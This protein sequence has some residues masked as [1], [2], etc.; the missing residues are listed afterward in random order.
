MA[1]PAVERGT[2]I[3]PPVDAPPA[4][5][6]GGVAAPPRPAPAPPRPAPAPA[7]PPA[8]PPAPPQQA[9]GWGL[10][11]VVLVTG[12][13]MSVLD[14]S[15]V[16]VAIPTMQNDFGVTTDEIQWVA[17]AYSLAL[18][19]VVPVSAYCADRFGPTRVYNISL[20]GFAA[21]SALCGLAWNLNSMIV[22]RVFQAI[23]G[24]V[25]PV[26]T[27]TILYRIVPKDRIG[28]A[29]GMY[30]LGIIV[31]PA[32]GPT[33]GGYLVEYVDWRLIFFINVPVGILGTIA[34]IVVLKK[35]P[36]VDNG[37]FDVVG[38]LC[39]ATG[40]F[41]LL[42]ALTE[43]Q[44]WGWTS[45]KV[46][47]L[48]TTGV[49]SLALFVIVELDVERPLLDVRV[50]RYWPFT[51]S[52]LLISVL[53]VGLFSVLFYVP[54]FLQQA[55]GLGA[56]E[57]GLL[58]LPQALV[59]AVCM[60]I[61]GRLYDRFGPRW[62]AVIGLSINAWG[63]YEMHVLTLDTT[64]A[65]LVWLLCLRAVGMGIGM[66][67]IMTGG[68]ASVPPSQV[69]RASAFN[70]VVQRTSAALGLAILTAVVTRT[71]AQLGDDRAGLMATGTAIPPMGPGATGRMMGTYAVYQQTQL[72]ILVAAMDKLF[73]LTAI[74]TVIGVALA[75]LLRSGPV[76]KAPGEPGHAVE[77]G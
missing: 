11:L 45:Y 42:L 9:G 35:F 70:N 32:V 55:Q 12:M 74:I 63:T 66:M 15:I 20:L 31:A 30:G 47:I 76:K 8:A 10:P 28:A 46:L 43:G 69:S 37:R 68:I 17:T 23:P 61:A 34:A 27:L 57:A 25:L 56:F 48:M 38:F 39:I 22:F 65:H 13:F 19:V 3:G 1:T 51:N 14:I 67:P 58:L 77:V 62:P 5:H 72:Q 54:L 4:D 33:L 26:V 53:S 49:L 40:L 29:M 73:I 24:G 16:N 64:H 18:G 2:R 59:M 21:G 7:A 36:G 60:P 6:N 71:Q 75:F 50:F 44:D 52:L 41:T